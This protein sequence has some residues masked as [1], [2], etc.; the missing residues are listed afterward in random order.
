MLLNSLHLKL[1]GGD[2]GGKKKKQHQNK[3]LNPGDLPT[4]QLFLY[5]PLVSEMK[6][7]K[8]NYNADRII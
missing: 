8:E 6:T 3:P 7:M 4:G 5:Q 2:K 1:G